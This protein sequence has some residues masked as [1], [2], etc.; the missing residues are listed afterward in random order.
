MTPKV[1]VVIPMYNSQSFIQ[2]TLLSIQNQ[3]MHNFECIVVNDS[4]TD[5]SVGIFKKYFSSDKRFH[6]ISLRANSGA[7]TARNVGLRRAKGKFICFLDADDLM[8]KESLEYRVSTLEQIHDDLI[9]GTYCGSETISEDIME[10]PKKSEFKS[11]KYK[12]FVTSGGACPFNSNQPMFITELLKKTGGFDEKLEQQGEDYEYWIRILRLGYYFILTPYKL[13]CYRN[14]RGSTVRQNVLNHLD[15]SYRWQKEVYEDYSEKDYAFLYDKP[16]SFYKLQFDVANRVFEFIGMAL[17]S[18]KNEIDLVDILIEKLPS[19]KLF[20][21][22]YRNAQ[23]I[24]MRGVKRQKIDINDV[25]Y[26]EEKVKSV[27]QLYDKKIKN[28]S[29]PINSGC[30]DMWL[31]RNY[32]VRYNPKLVFLPHKDYHVWTISLLEGILIDSGI[33]YEVVDLSCHYRDERVREKAKELDINLIGYSNW[34]LSQS[35]TDLIVSFNDWD[36][37]VRSIIKCAQFS[38]ICTATIVEGIQDY[39]DADTG[40]ERHAYRCS[41]YV[42]LPGNFDKKYFA[43]S[44]QNL[45]VMGLPRVQKIY[46]DYKNKVANKR[47]EK[48]VLVNCNFSY[49]VLEDKRDLWLKDVIEAC[50]NVGLEPVISRH[51][52]DKGQLYPEYVTKGSFYEELDKCKFYVSRFASGV[53]EALA[54]GLKVIYYNPN[55][56]KVDK[57][58][59][60]RG[61]YSLCINKKELKE[62]LT[63]KNTKY[64]RDLIERFLVDHC[65]DL[66]LIDTSKLVEL[67]KLSES[68]YNEWKKFKEIHQVLDIRTGCFNNIKVLRENLAAS[69][70]TGEVQNN[71]LV[72]FLK[73]EDTKFVGKLSSETDSMLREANRLYRIGKFKEAKVI[74]EDLIDSSE[75]Y[76][77]LKINIYLCEKQLEK[78][79]YSQST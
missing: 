19:Y 23:D 22:R 78:Y 44:S 50:I 72:S 65:G 79:T 21:Y 47:S 9:I 8:M 35:P 30:N 45:S 31:S 25:S 39:L 11:S 24:I 4:S 57:F 36:P 41:D 62:A 64:N 71:D 13:V 33:D 58:M 68:T 70:S 75:F 3:T 32:K 60:P 77:F 43:D 76:D 28:L 6:L 12:D 59:N 51:P 17:A 2:S 1:T 26:Y 54:A 66:S 16:L 34:I 14:R 67:A 18:G 48:K 49:G 38:G 5:D 10:P 69:Y 63:N 52:A 53:L 37:I 40:Q 73:L 61:A 15:V 46:N 55:I 27:L 20:L 74:F 7:C 29:L 56:E 42:F